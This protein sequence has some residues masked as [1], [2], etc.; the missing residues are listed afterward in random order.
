MLPPMTI[1]QYSISSSPLWNPQHV[2]LTISVVDAPALSGMGRHRGV[3][4]S[5][6]ASR[7][8]GDRVSIAVRPSNSRFHPPTDTSKPI[9]LICAGSGIA[10]F[11]GF[12]QERS[13][14]K[15][16][17]RKVGPALLFFGVDHPDVDFLYRDELAAWERDGVVTVL[18][19]FSARPEG[20]VSFVQH[21]VWSERARIA[22]LFQEGATVFVCGD[23]KQMA[24]AVRD[25]LIKTYREASGAS[26]DEAHVWADVI[27]R[28]QGRY[29][30]DVFS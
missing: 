28:E 3:A 20:D 4:S 10:P 11:R 24:P 9:V 12:L 6:M 19:A 7:A 13:I 21:R 22:K 5:Y 16:N 26:E 15:S 23:G 30:S 18:P 25:T 17:G 29:V 1:R 2:T 27:E 14:Q 8:P